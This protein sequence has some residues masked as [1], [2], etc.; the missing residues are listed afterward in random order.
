MY[1]TKILFFNAIQAPQ[2]S[3]KASEMWKALSA[4][5]RLHWDNEAV[6]EKQRY[7][8]EKE[9]YTGPVSLQLN[10]FVFEKGNS[11]QTVFFF[12]FLF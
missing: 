12:A 5:D 3:K 7:L 6:K 1:L 10:F 11:N 9:A 2:V 8:V 4:E